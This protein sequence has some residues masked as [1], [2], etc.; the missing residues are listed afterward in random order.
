MT[1]RVLPTPTH[2]LRGA[3]P[4]P[5]REVC[6]CSRGDRDLRV[7]VNLSPSCLCDPELVKR[8]RRTL[9]GHELPGAL[10]GLE[11]TEQSLDLGPEAANTAQHL[12]AMDVSLALDDF[13]IGHS[14]LYRLSQI[15]PALPADEL[16]RWIDARGRAARGGRSS[17][18]SE[19]LSGLGG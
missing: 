5:R 1:A 17:G 6:I 8:V 7:H 10:L 4:L 12:A 16:E 3:R 18:P 19:A 14:S 13:G 9:D 11:V 15:Q 2:R